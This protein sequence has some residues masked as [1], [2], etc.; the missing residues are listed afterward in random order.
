VSGI[1]GGDTIDLSSLDANA[2]AAGNQAFQFIGT[3]A[4]S[5]AGQVRYVQQG[6]DTIIEANTNNATGNIEFE[7]RLLGPHA[8][9][10]GDFIL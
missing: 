1:V 7:L 9:K 10:A 3:A 5:A 2:G 4:F 8:L 6:G